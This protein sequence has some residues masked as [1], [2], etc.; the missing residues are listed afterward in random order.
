[1]LLLTF[2]AAILFFIFPSNGLAC[3]VTPPLITEIS[4]RPAT[5]DRGDFIQ[6]LSVRVSDKS[7]SEIDLEISAIEGA[8]ATGCS[9]NFRWARSYLLELRERRPPYFDSMIPG[10]TNEEVRSASEPAPRPADKSMPPQPPAATATA[11]PAGPAQD[12]TRDPRSPQ[13]VRFRNQ[14]VQQLDR[15]QGSLEDISPWLESRTSTLSIG[16]L[17]HLKMAI[18]S[19]CPS[20][21]VCPHSIVFGQS[22]IELIISRRIREEENRRFEADLKQERELADSSWWSTVLGGLIAA[23]SAGLVAIIAAWFGMRQSRRD[24]ANLQDVL[25]RLDQTLADRRVAGRPA[26]RT[27]MRLYRF[28]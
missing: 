5:E 23:V 26:S 6:W 25:G 17:E 15:W 11:R 16:E 21:R 12:Q 1:M 7:R 24:S 4:G 13:N 2:L 27:R 18:L 10:G 28:R 8:C 19:A 22:T 9:D 14:I 3:C 20:D